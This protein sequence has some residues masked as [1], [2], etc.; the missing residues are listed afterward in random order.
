MKY[1][2]KLKKIS[3]LN[4]MF[5]LLEQINIERL[6]T[7]FEDLSN[8]EAVIT[9][10]DKRKLSEKQRKLYRALLNDIFIWSGTD[11]NALHEIFKE[12]YFV[13]TGERISTANKSKNNMS[14]MN[15]LLEIVI[16]FM[17][18]WNVPFAKG[19]ELLPRN[20]Q[21]YLYVCCKHRKCA[22]CG[23]PADIHH[24]GNKVGAGRN[25]NNYDHSS[26]TFVAL[27]RIHHV[28]RHT[29]TWELFKD[30]YQLEAIKLTFET[31]QKLGLM[32][33]KLIDEIRGE[34]K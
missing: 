25:R 29:T 9:F 1:I 7:I 28:E 13:E 4:V 10:Y 5:E 23:K 27:C 2:A 33:Q 6:K 34:N 19:Y 31:L 12:M 21:Y 24:E 18:E 17:F 26:S 11:T 15:L 30:K 3:G 32:T 8:V 22:V 14:D 16:D 20:A